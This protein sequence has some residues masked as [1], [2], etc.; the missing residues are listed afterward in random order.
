MLQFI[1]TTILMASLGTMLYLVARSIPRV[2]EEVSD[3]KSFLDRFA[4]SEIPEKIDTAFNGFLLKYLRK[5]KIVLLKVDNFITEKLKKISSNGNL[6]HFG[7]LTSKPK[8][9]LKD[10]SG[11]P[12]ASELTEKESDLDSKG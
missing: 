4:S 6:K 7:K 5:L 12:V 11:D 9:D 8:I 2:G 1:L 3:K 10:I